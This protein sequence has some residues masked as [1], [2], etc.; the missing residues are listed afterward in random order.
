MNEGYFSKQRAAVILDPAIATRNAGDE[1]ISQACRHWIRKA[2]PTHFLSPVPTHE[3][4]GTRSWRLLKQS[5]YAIVGGSNILTSNL[6]FDRGWRLSPRDAFFAKDLILLA[7]GWREYQK[8][9]NRSTKALL[10]RVLSRDGV[11]SVRDSHTYEMMRNA[12]FENVVMTSCV[13][14][15]GLTPDHLA[16]IPK[17]KADAV[18]TTFTRGKPSPADK[19]MIDLLVQQYGNVYIWPQGFNDYDYVLEM[20][21]GRA[22]VLA[23]TLEAYDELLMGDE[24]VDY[25]GVRLHAGIR[26]LQKKRRAFIIAID[27][28]A[29]EISRD[30]GLGAIPRGENPDIIAAR[31]NK[32]FVSELRLPQDAIDTWLSQFS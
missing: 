27:N 31:L 16:S 26:A 32:P 14:M 25:V 18:V 19:A 7:V 11:H 9:P 8:P 15:W 22:T 3:K 2:L 28:R 12:G 20:S 13:T 30:T 17:E 6:L 23:P 21:Q 24:P 1:V 29:T 4:M 10:N 5:E